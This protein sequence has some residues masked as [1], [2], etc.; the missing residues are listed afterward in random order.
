MRRD[1]R[2]RRRPARDDTDDVSPRWV[3]SGWTIFNNKG[4]PVRQYEPFFSDTH[5]FEFDVAHRRQ[6]GAVLRP[7]R[8]RR[9]HAAPEPH[10]REGGVR[11][12]A[13]DD[14]RRQRHLRRRATHRPATR[15]PTPTSAATSREYFK[16]CQPTPA[17]QT[18]HAQRIGG[19]LGTARAATPPSA[20]QPMPTRPPPRTSTRW[21]APS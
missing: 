10:L 2:R 6:P 1:H 21:A 13:A 5:R 9:R 15:A 3:G 17:W 19:A 11:P 14:L 12:L 20:P 7:G 8:A 4:K 16:R 18:W